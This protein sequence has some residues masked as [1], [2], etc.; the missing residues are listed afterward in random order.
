[1]SSNFVIAELV[2]INAFNSLHN[3]AMLP[4]IVVYVLEMNK[5]LYLVYNKTIHFK[6]FNFLIF[7]RKVRNKA[8]LWVNF[9]FVV[10]TSA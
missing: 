10:G 9:Y 5:F 1:M 7:H 4:T 8:I 2:F 6:L 3:D